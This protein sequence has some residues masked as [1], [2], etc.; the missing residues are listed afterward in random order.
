[1]K[2]IQSNSLSSLFSKEACSSKNVDDIIVGIAQEYDLNE[3]EI[4]EMIQGLI[5]EKVHDDNL[6]ELIASAFSS[7]E[8][9]SLYDPESLPA[10]METSI[11]SIVDD[12]EISKRLQI[13]MYQLNEGSS[14]VNDLDALGIQAIAYFQSPSKCSYPDEHEY[15]VK[16][17]VSI[18]SHT[19]HNESGERQDIYRSIG[20]YIP[21]MM[22]DLQD[23]GSLKK[24]VLDF[25]YVL[26]DSIQ[27]KIYGIALYELVGSMPYNEKSSAAFIEF[28]DEVNVLLAI[29]DSD[30]VCSKDDSIYESLDQIVQE[31]VLYG[32]CAS[33]ALGKAFNHWSTIQEFYD[34]RLPQIHDDENLLIEEKKSLSRI[35]KK[36][37]FRDDFSNEVMLVKKLNERLVSVLDLSSKSAHEIN[38]I[39]YVCKS[40]DF[41]VRINCK[42]TYMQLQAISNRKRSLN[43]NSGESIGIKKA[44]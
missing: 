16:A 15:D 8:D 12:S 18:Y 21:L 14:D 25:G 10:I 30:A 40:S 20:E 36:V 3:A 4:E 35:S 41:N 24:A 2:M 5:Q 7:E 31:E 32:R 23:L 37:A 9:S 33:E 39:L 29:P 28:F 38:R 17:Y 34:V 44:G 1:M 22:S 26:D 42:R 11:Y 6:E 43:S 13:E 19:M 27:L